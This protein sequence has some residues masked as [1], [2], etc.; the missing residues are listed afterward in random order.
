MFFGT[1][2]Y[3][4]GTKMIKVNALALKSVDYRDNDKMISLYSLE[5]GLI[6]ACVRGAKKAGSKTRVLHSAVLFCRVCFKR[7]KRP[8]N[9]NGRDRDRKFL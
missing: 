4:L 3:L 1:T 9:G 7:K 5:K 8:F 6:G 2:F